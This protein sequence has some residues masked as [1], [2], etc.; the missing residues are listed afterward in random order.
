MS[1]ISF[2]IYDIYVHLYI[3]DLEKNPVP[4]TDEHTQIVRQVK[5]R[6]KSL[7]CLNIPNPAPYMI[8][9]TGAS[10]IGYGGTLK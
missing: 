6:V 1:L 9:E 5:A 7:P 2:P 8:L 4:W 3:E 10:D